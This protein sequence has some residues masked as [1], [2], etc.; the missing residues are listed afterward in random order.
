MSDDVTLLYRPGQELNDIPGHGA[1]RGTS[2]EAIV[3]RNNLGEF[4][5]AVLLRPLWFDE[6]QQ[7][8]RVEHSLNTMTLAER[9]TL[10]I[11][12]TERSRATHSFEYDPLR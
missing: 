4:L 9:V 1:P 11:E 6:S 8:Q 5:D 3:S 2:K 7:M 12:M 10:E